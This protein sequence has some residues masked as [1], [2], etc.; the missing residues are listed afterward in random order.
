MDITS[1]TTFTVCGFIFN[2]SDVE[3]SQ[4]H[5]SEIFQCSEDIPSEYINWDIYSL[6]AMRKFYPIMALL[7]FLIMFSNLSIMVGVLRDARLRKQIFLLQI[8]GQALTDLMVGALILIF[9]G[10][11]ILSDWIF[12]GEETGCNFFGFA[13]VTTCHCTVF[14]LSW[15]AH[16]RYRKVV[17]NRN[18]SVRNLRN[19]YILGVWGATLF[20]GTYYSFMTKARLLASGAFCNPIYNWAVLIPTGTFVLLP[21]LYIVSTY[22][23]VYKVMHR[24]MAAAQRSKSNDVSAPSSRRTERGRGVR[25]FFKR[26]SS[27]SKQQN[28]ENLRR[29]SQRNRATRLMIIMC[30]SIFA[31]WTP[32]Y[33]YFVFVVVSLIRG[34]KAPGQEVAEMCLGLSAAFSSLCSPIVYGF[35]NQTLRDAMI[36]AFLP[37]SWKVSSTFCNQDS[38]TGCCDMQIAT[39][40]A[41][42]TNIFVTCSHLLMVIYHPSFFVQLINHYKETFSK[43]RAKSNSKFY[44]SKGPAAHCSHILFIEVRALGPF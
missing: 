11:T 24:T 13:I 29:V 4:I 38:N 19:G 37:M 33:I 25:T 7:G 30:G 21:I 3:A 36:F 26:Y 22:Y 35:C 41:A 16:A 32:L 28:N 44:S 1:G 12:L 39:M 5:A 23:S 6:S 34:E 8:V 15:I 31:L 2:T 42:L 10:G 27:Q 40:T 9:Y 43:A 14:S 17:K 18:V 20:L